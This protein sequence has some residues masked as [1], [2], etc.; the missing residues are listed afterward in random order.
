MTIDELGYD[1]IRLGHQLGELAE[2]SRQ[3]FA[4]IRHEFAT[5]HTEMRGILRA[6]E[7]LDLHF[8]ARA[9]RW[10][11]DSSRLYRQFNDLDCRVRTLE[12]R[13]A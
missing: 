7:T 5:V 9:S 6:G 11:E 8:S 4:G 10:N 2:A 12:K 1:V 13:P 3:E